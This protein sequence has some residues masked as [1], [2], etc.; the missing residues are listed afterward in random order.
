M[1]SYLQS[2][3]GEDGGE[4]GVLTPDQVVIRMRMVLLPLIRS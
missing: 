2:G 3:C 4:D 1:D